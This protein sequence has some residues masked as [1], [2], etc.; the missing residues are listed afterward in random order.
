MEISAT[1]FPK[2]L[3]IESGIF[4]EVIPLLVWPWEISVAFLIPPEVEPASFTLISGSGLICSPVQIFVQSSHWDPC[5]PFTAPNC[6]LSFTPSK[7]TNTSGLTEASYHISE[8]GNVF[9]P[10][11]NWAKP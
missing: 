10:P 9:I 1:L 4:F 11:E 5:P 7:L 2:L 8:S 3:L 6:Q